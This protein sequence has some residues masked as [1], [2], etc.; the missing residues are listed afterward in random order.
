MCSYAYLYTVHT[1]VCVCIMNI[2]EFMKHFQEEFLA[3][4]VV[5][6][7]WLVEKLYNREVI[8]KALKNSILKSTDEYKMTSDIFNHVK[9][10]GD[11]DSLRV[12]C[13]CM[14]NHDGFR[15]MDALGKKMLKCLEASE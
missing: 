6:S 10:Q 1:Y 3:E 4:D 8:P 15:K 7:E 2:I 12:M 5:Q 9:G 13:K 11:Y 14:I